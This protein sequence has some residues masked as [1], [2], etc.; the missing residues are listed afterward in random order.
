MKPVSVRLSHLLM[1]NGVGSIIHTP[2]GYFVVEDIRSWDDRYG[3]ITAVPIPYVERVKVALG[4]SRELREPPSAQIKQNVVKGATVPI[5]RFP[6][7]TQCRECSTLH[8]NPWE[9]QQNE[10][11]TCNSCDSKAPLK[12]LLWVIV[13]PR[14]YLSE[15]DWQRKTHE[16]Q[17]D[18]N[19]KLT[20]G[21]KLID[22]D[23]GPM[24]TCSCGSTNRF[25]SKER[26]FYGNRTTQPWLQDIASDLEE[27][28]QSNMSQV[29]S[30]DDSRIYS[31][32]SREVLVIP[33]ESRVR[34]GTVV[35]EL[36]RNSTIV[37]NLRNSRTQLIRKRNE[38]QLARKYRC[39]VDDI[40]EA[41][42]EIEAGYP[43]YGETFTPE[44]IEQLEYQAFQDVI[45]DMK[46]DEDFVV[47]NN[48]LQWQALVAT[49]GEDVQDSLRLVSQLVRVDRLKSIK[50]F[51][52]F[53]RL[54]GET[55]IPPDID[56]SRDWLPAIQLY[57]E[58]IFFVLDPNMLE[59]WETREEVQRRFT[60]VARRFEQSGSESPNPLTPRF[61]LLHTL[62]HL[63][64]R[65]LEFEGGYPAA[66][67]AERIYCSPGANGMAGI[68]IWTAV[69]DLAGSLG[70]LAELAEPSRFQKLLFGAIDHASWCSMDPVCGESSG[71]GVGMLNRAACHGCSLVPD[72][73]CI[74]GN[75][76]L[77]RAFIRGNLKDGLGSIFEMVG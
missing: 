21:M 61:I 7:W 10:K 8:F 13:D 35:D 64:M 28:S 14:G 38:S 59:R 36:Y 22:S 26:L 45:P 71:Q 77:D 32:V 18:P 41:M 73:A 20:T 4:T 53:K 33:P 56:A 57:G 37:D 72:T 34:K 69:A 9:M 76:L 44:M 3:R 15:M 67:L 46:S 75:V 17:G 66:S 47:Q 27:R 74:Y 42:K 1:Q 31:A 50:A 49:K 55:I 63:M 60:T 16:K 52:G 12:Q 2:D 30:I 65:Q 48:S 11:P 39:S 6:K 25:Y 29:L 19:C 51:L 24:L 5:Q 40:H 43:L 62:A 58:G 70:G 54:D 23:D 68:L